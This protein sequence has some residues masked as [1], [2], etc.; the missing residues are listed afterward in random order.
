MSTPSEP[1]EEWDL[2]RALG[3]LELCE[4]DLFGGVF[5]SGGPESE[6]PRTRDTYTGSMTVIAL[7]CL[8]C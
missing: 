3:A 5:V 4:G 7:E 2:A 8:C 6:S 1:V